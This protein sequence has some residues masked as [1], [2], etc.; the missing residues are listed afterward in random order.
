MR[1]QTFLESFNSTE[2]V[3]VYGTLRDAKT[4]KEALG[5]EIS[6]TPAKV[7]GELKED[8]NYTTIIPGGG[9]VEGQIMEL[10]PEQIARLDK[11]EADY[12]RH[13][14]SLDSGEEVWA[15]SRKPEFGSDGKPV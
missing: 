5:A 10:T 4:R 6:T 9:S 11:W 3:F 1:L 13:K 15:Y 14:V 7:E 2:K 8:E 12:T